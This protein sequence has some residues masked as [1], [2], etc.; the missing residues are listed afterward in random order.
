MM[1]LLTLVLAVSIHSAAVSGAATIRPPYEDI[2]LTK[3]IATPKAEKTANPSAS[4]ASSLEFE[5]FSSCV[6]WQVESGSS[7][8]SALKTC[9]LDYYPLFKPKSG[10]NPPTDCTWS[11]SGMKHPEGGNAMDTR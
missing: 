1:R 9:Y 6:S 10:T 5:Q 8:N 11:G 3:T 4:L 7:V 2:F